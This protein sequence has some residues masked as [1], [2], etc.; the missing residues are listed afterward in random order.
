M[1]VPIM[2]IMLS[3]VLGRV[4]Q[5]YTMTAMAIADAVSLI[6]TENVHTVVDAGGSSGSLIHAQMRQNPRLHGIVLDLPSVTPAAEKS[7]AAAGSSD[8][9]RATGLERQAQRGER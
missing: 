7:A 2:Y 9:P 6:D 3:N 5:D 1:P 8:R 4:W